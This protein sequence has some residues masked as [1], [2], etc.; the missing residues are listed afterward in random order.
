MPVPFLRLISGGV[1][2]AAV[3]FCQTE[4]RY[5]TNERILRIRELGKKKTA[6]LPE[7]TSY[8]TDPN[9]D[10]RIEAVKAIIKI[11]TER[12]LDPLI[13]A[14]RDRDEDVEIRATD[15]LVNFYVPGYVA[16]GG[17]TGSMTRGVR[18]V[19]GFFASRND[20]M[21]DADV[22]VRPDV[23][24][25]ISDL[26]AKGA[27]S[28]ARANAALAA[29]IL[30]DEA[31][32]PT[33]LQALHAKDDD[34]LFESLIALQKINDPAAGPQIGFLAHDL[35]ER[36]QATALETIGLLRASSDAPDVRSALQT[37]RNN[38]IR[39]AA[40]KALA[41]LGLPEDRPTFLQFAGDRD[42]DL[43]SSALEGLGRVREPQDFPALQTAFDEG[44][45]DWRI[46]L[47]AAFAMVNQG[48]VDGSEFSPL[49]YLVENVAARGRS[50]AAANY[51]KELV[52]NSGVR[53]ALSKM[54]P[55]MA[56]NQKIALCP[57]FAASNAPDAT[58]TLNT[59]AKDIDPDVAF[60]ASKALRTLQTRR[61]S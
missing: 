41:V 27:G 14:T 28:N 4:D 30:R 49:A 60:A 38:R 25:A 45:A 2:L 9:R 55:E 39:R 5:N 42:V 22:Q 17:L 16:K 51:L 15:G 35:E 21:I 29:G 13:T 36:I 46:H 31:A 24:Q 34:L 10:I 23:A 18:Q 12:S 56:K 8:L 40:L 3:G 43:R 20:Q 11:D 50:D 54:L 57:V 33:L 61:A 59:L 32:M 26:V 44:E 53:A 58:A 48:K 37:A 47:A 6:V 1:L 52:P 19:K 7:I